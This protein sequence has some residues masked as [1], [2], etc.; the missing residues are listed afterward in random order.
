MSLPACWQAEKKNT[1]QQL[2]DLGFSLELMSRAK[3]IQL[4]DGAVVSWD[5]LVSQ[6]ICAGV[7]DFDDFLEAMKDAVRMPMYNRIDYSDVYELAKEKA[8]KR[9]VQERQEE[10]VKQRRED[11]N[12]PKTSIPEDVRSV[13]KRTL[14]GTEVDGD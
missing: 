12:R 14:K 4:V 13:L 6:D 9:R 8:K 11:A 10:A 1:P 3:S 7:F 2:K 5:L